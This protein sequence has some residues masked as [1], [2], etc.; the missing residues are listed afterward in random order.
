[1]NK[2]SLAASFSNAHT[3]IN[4]VFASNKSPVAPEPLVKVNSSTSISLKINFGKNNGQHVV[5]SNGI[6]K[7]STLV[8]Y[9]EE[10]DSDDSGK[11]T[12][13]SN[14]ESK[15]ESNSVS[16]STQDCKSNGKVNSMILTKTNNNEESK[17]T[18]PILKVKATTNSWQVVETTSSRKNNDDNDVKTTSN[19]KI[20]KTND[21][22]K[23]N[24]KSS[25]SPEK[26]G[27]S[28]SSSSQQEK[29]SK[30]SDS[31]DF[32][33][34]TEESHRIKKKK[35]KKKEKKK[36]KK[37]KEK[38]KKLKSS[39]QSDDSDFESTELSWVERTK[40]TLDME[41]SNESTN[42]PGLQSKFLSKLLS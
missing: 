37:N 11:K 28:S 9:G 6:S 34:R 7:T 19:W 16:T 29:S 12:K 31:S 10:E 20:S 2:S 32:D 4:S 15:P 27:S 38:K 25:I 30:S 13:K 3:S 22:V 40:E 39:Q 1:M 17:A 26:N 35:E 41:N 18:I 14:G 36:H 8:P 5:C 42:I 23:E 21:L 24:K 33:S